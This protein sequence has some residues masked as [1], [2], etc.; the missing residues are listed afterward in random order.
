M[1][2]GGRREEWEGSVCRGKEVLSLALVD[3]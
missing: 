3:W 2:R 1:T